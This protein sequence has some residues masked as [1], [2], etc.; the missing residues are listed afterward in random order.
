MKKRLISI[1]L[2]I[3]YNAL[4]IVVMVFKDIPTIRIGHL[5]LN[6][7]GTDGDHPANFIPF[8]TIVPYLLGFKG[9]IIAG[10]NLVGNIVLL[11]PLGLLFPFVY[12]RITWKKSLFF[13][14]ATGL[15]IET[16]QAVFQVGVFDI[17]DVILNALGVMLGFWI[18]SMFAAWFQA[19]TVR[20]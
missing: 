9:W 20:T 6:F 15:A 10:V 1:I 11:V 4:L 5:M 18:C 14:I 12:P 8:S 16:M 3:A 17:D 19:K 13:A 7:G 2:F